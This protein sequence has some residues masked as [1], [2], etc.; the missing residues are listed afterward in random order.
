MSTALDALLAPRPPAS[1]PAVFIDHTAFGAH[2]ILRRPLPWTEAVE[3]AAYYGQAQAMLGSDATVLP[4][5]PL[6]EAVL[7]E[8]PS[9]RSGMAARSRT[10]Y[11]L[12]TLLAGEEVRDAVGRAVSA[13][14]HMSRAPLVLLTPS[15]LVW[16]ATAQRAAGNPDLSG[17]TEEHA[18][19]AAMY[20]SDWLRCLAEA[21]VASL[22]LDG[23]RGGIDGLA[24]EALGAYSPVANAAEHY[25]WGL[26][27]LTDG[28]ATVEGGGLSAQVLSDEYWTRGAQAPDADLLPDEHPGHRRAGHGPRTARLLA[29]R[30]GTPATRSR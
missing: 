1:P 21:S 9:L 15:P 10:G 18:E 29:L 8:H 27:H 23:R 17:I 28:G 4:V 22:V 5:Q 2:R 30:T 20:V 3:L 12:R 25:R 16:L 26:V 14:P 19:S 7:A 6:I 24:A 13:I 11:A